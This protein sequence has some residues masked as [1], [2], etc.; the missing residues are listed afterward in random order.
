MFK[1][2]NIIY[3]KPVTPILNT[4][5]GFTLIEIAVA[6]LVLAIGILGVAGMQSVGVRES[7]NT[8][9][10]SQAN[11]LVEDMAN[12]MRAN[13]AE[14][15]LGV[16][17]RYL[18]QTITADSCN[19]DGDLCDAGQVA[20]LDLSSWVEAVENSG[21]PNVGQAI[22]FVGNVEINGV[23]VTSTYDIQVFWDE[24]KQGVTP[25]DCAQASGCVSWRVQI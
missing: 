12:K 8:Y 15:A 24:A 22:Q 4:Q 25:D 20:D 6:V 13:Q 7:Q 21:L 9:F 14:A 3:K 16:G 1:T 2:K 11:L 23:A 17:S 5:S 19:F 18:A 10:R